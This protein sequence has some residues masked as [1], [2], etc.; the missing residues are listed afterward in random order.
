MVVVIVVVTIGVGSMVAVAVAVVGR[1]AK[2]SSCCCREVRGFPS[3]TPSRACTSS[4]L[5]ASF[6]AVPEAA[7]SPVFFFFNFPPRPASGASSCIPLF[8]P[9]CLGVGEEEVA[10][11]GSVRNSS[12]CVLCCVKKGDSASTLGF[13]AS[14]PRVDDDPS[15]TGS[16]TEEEGRVLKEHCCACCVWLG[17]FISIWSSSS[18]TLSRSF[19][20]AATSASH[21]CSEAFRRAFLASRDVMRERRRCWLA[22]RAA[23]GARGFTS[24]ITGV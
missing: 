4:G 10:C 18:S 5:S 3:P 23:R 24:A 9:S 14:Q 11:D 8:P 20:A 19:R 21:C 1:G 22:R 15:S 13:E 12:I 7:D 2:G 6:E 16:E 17:M